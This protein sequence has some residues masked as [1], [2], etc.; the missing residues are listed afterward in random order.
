MEIVFMA[1]TSFGGL[2][3]DFSTTRPRCDP[4]IAK[5]AIWFHMPPLS[6]RYQENMNVAVCRM[7]VCG[8]DLRI[9]SSSKGS[10]E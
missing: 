2:V 8:L 3:G 7:V 9:H 4:S 1:D 6:S 10:F 5:Q